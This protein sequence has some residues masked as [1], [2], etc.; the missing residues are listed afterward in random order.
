MKFRLPKPTFWTFVLAAI[1]AAGLFSTLYRFYY[2]LG[3]ATHLSDRFP[4]GIWIGFDILIGVGLAAGGFAIA[5]TVY[6]F[7]L[8]AYKPIARST[9]LTAFLGYVLVITAL[10]FDLGKPY[11]VWHVIIMWN[12]HSVMFEVGW[13]VMLYTTVLFLEFL[14]VVFERFRLERWQRLFHNI[15]IPLVI[16]GVL[17]STLHQS[18]LGTLYVLVASKLHPLWYSGMLPVFFFISAIAG[19]LAMVIFESYLSARAFGKELEHALLVNL[20]RVIAVVIGIY[21]V[22]R[23]QDMAGRGALN[24]IVD[25]SAESI[26]FLVEILLGFVTP[27]VLFFIPRVRANKAWLFFGAVLVLFGFIMNR[28]NVAIT[29][30]TR[31]SGV[32]YLPSW[33]EL[34]VTL[35]VVAAGI[36]AFRFAVKFLPVFGANEELGVHPPPLIAAGRSGRRAMA[37]LFAI[38][39]LLVAGLGWSLIMHKPNLAPPAPDPAKPLAAESLSY[40]API[41]FTKAE[42]SPGQVTFNHESH[43]DQAEPN[44]KGCHA[45]LFSVRPPAAPAGQAAAAPTGVG[46]TQCGTCHNGEKAFNYEESCDGCHISTE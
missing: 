21:L 43:V 4:W 9:I 36:V 34:A 22:L 29:G 33:M 20:S 46:H 39:L 6:I 44:C 32:D 8:K 40:P 25:G 31:Y 28:L 27:M 19:G 42:A 45:G 23:I 1:W 26:Y 37:V 38:L 11:N 12:P 41:A 16:I 7:N 13:C 18:S 35:S 10:M 5:A 17:L 3:A 24:Y 14:P 2:G 30:M 15:T